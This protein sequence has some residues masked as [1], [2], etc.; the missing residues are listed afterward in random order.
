MPFKSKSQL[1]TCYARKHSHPSSTWNCDEWLRKTPDIGCLPE[2]KGKRPK[3]ACRNQRKDE[4]I[5]GKI[6]TGPR[7]G[8]YFIIRQGEDEIKVYV[9]K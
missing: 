5:I 6:M 9:K 7:G 2:K 4:K 8:K 1:R 3:R